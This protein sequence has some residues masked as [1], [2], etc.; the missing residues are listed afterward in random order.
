M[1]K[2]SNAAPVTMPQR[3]SKQVCWGAHADVSVTHAPALMCLTQLLWQAKKR[4]V[5]D[6]EEDT[7][8]VQASPIQQER[9]TKRQ[10]QSSTV[11]V[12]NTGVC[13]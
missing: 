8:E 3:N 4:R 1:S 9:P 7:T 10:R 13:M 5:R 2:A 6:E 12:E 11:C